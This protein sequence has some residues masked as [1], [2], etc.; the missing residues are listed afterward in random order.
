MSVMSASMRRKQEVQEFK[1]SLG[2]LR[3]LSAPQRKQNNNTKKTEIRISKK[4]LYVH[5]YMFISIAVFL[6]I[7]KEKM[8]QMSISV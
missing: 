7:T 2:Y 6:T 8:T 3:P 5:V 1:G 4:Y